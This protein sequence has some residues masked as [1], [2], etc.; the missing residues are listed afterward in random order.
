MQMLM[1]RVEGE[2]EGRP[3]NGLLQSYVGDVLLWSNGENICF[4]LTVKDW[5]CHRYIYALL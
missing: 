2:G 4:G 5:H 1:A 3:G